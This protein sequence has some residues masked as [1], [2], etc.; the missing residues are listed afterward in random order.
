M[1]I[2]TF[3]AKGQ[4]LIPAELRKKFGITK[5]TPVNVYEK[6]NKIII[7]PIKKDLVKAGR[8]LLKTNGRVLKNLIASR[9]AEEAEL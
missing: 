7:E 9:A 8:G 2:V 5:G 1:T 4:I 6:E 3:T